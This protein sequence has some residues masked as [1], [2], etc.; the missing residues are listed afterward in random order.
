MSG[1]TY[2]DNTLETLREIVPWAGGNPVRDIL[3]R[4][5]RE[6]IEVVRI[7]IQREREVAKVLPKEAKEFIK[8]PDIKALLGDV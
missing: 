1:V 2:G 6:K 5:N 7:L 3:E 8:I 4:K